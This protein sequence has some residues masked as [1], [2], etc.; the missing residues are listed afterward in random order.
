VT[1]AYAV[2]AIIVGAD[3]AEVARGFSR[4]TDPA[5]HAEESALAK[6][7]VTG[8]DLSRATIYTSLEPCSIRR[9]RSRSCTELI[10][11]AGIRRVVFAMREPPTFVDCRGA[12]T[13]LEAGIEVVELTDLAGLVRQVN[14]H[15]FGPE[16]SR[17]RR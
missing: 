4:E 10:L 2:G 12:E 3:G 15:L 8:A 9:S 17:G 16:A 11:A 6:A 13:L 5:D 1:T 7:A 14:A